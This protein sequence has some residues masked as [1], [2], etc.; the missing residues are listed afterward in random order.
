MARV[1]VVDDEKGIRITFAEI[2]EEHG[3]PA[4]IDNQ[5]KIDVCIEWSQNEEI[6]QGDQD[7]GYLD[8]S[9]K[10]VEMMNNQ[11]FIDEVPEMDAVYRN[12]E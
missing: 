10:F 7:Q 4:N 5:A 11:G 12:P 1:L 9:W 6:W 3:G 2:L 8:A